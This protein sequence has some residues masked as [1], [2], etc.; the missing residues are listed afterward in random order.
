MT[1]RKVGK[2]LAENDVFVQHLG[3]GWNE[4]RYFWTMWNHEHE[5]DITNPEDYIA[6][7][8]NP[9]TPQIRELPSPCGEDELG[10]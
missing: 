3:V 7:G 2:I 5:W 4:W 1:G 9:G 6:S 10:C 8:P